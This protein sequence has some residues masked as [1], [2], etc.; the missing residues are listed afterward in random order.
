[1]KKLRKKRIQ[2]MAFLMQFIQGFLSSIFP[3]ISYSEEKSGTVR[4]IILS[5]PSMEPAGKFVPLYQA[6][7]TYM[8]MLD[9]DRSMIDMQTESRLADFDTWQAVMRESCDHL[10]QIFNERYPGLMRL[11]AQKLP[12][13]T[14]EI[15]EFMLKF[16]EGID[17]FKMMYGL[18]EL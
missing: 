9:T 14:N 4:E 6:Y 10:I 15:N 16:R 13:Q 2:K 7:L 12:K 8:E 11:Q 17:R 3:Q 18:I 5:K 1:M